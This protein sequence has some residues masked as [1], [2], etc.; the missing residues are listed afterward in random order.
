MAAAMTPPER[1]GALMMGGK[2]DRVPVVPFVLGYAAQITGISLG[3]FYA[4]GNQCFEAQFAAMRLHGYEM[5][6]M[7]GY[8]CCGAWEFG[9]KVGFPYDAAYGAPHVIEHPVKTPADVERLEVPTFKKGSLPGAYREADKLARRCI[10]LGMPATVQ[11]GSVFTTAANVV[12]TSKLLTWIFREPK[13]VHLLM[14]KVTQMFI[15]ALEY[16]A[17]E[18]GPENCLPFDGGP[19]E[20]NTVISPKSFR[21]FA[22]PYVQKVHQKVKDLG[23]PAVLMHPCAD[24]NLN[25][26]YYIEL[27][28]KLGWSGKYF[29]LFGPETP[30]DVQIKSFGD[31]DI[32]CGNVD[33]PSI[34]FKSYE[35]VFQLCKENIEAGKDSPNGFVLSPGCEL[36]PLAP[37]VKVMAMMEAAEQFGRYE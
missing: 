12:E 35:E 37:P 10:E 11:S 20:A 15:N 22:Y 8:A 29:W 26:P 19:V 21:D 4:D 1:M 34:Q 7:Y 27:R 33:P 2:P 9:G 24:Q 3:D 16:F 36:P 14:E 23:I 28:E 5:T 25:L 18:Y 6:P 17:S 32:I 30:L 13:T 31:H